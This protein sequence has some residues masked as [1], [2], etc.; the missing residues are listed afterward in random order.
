MLT[1][2]RT[3]VLSVATLIQGIW[4][5]DATEWDDENREWDS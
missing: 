5:L 3:V 1:V 4:N 2:F